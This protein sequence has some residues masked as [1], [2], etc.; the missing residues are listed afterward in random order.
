M[1]WCQND[2]MFDNIEKN[3]MISL[4][5]LI[6]DKQTALRKKGLQL[7]ICWSFPMWFPLEV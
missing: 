1:P 6:H 3:S 7:L 2:L 5:T 4:Y